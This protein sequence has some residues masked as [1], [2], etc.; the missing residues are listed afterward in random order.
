M[1]MSIG[2]IIEVKHYLYKDALLTFYNSFKSDYMAHCKQAWG[3]AYNSFIKTLFI[4]QENSLRIMFN[5]H[6]KSL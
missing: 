5:T 2:M 1:S 6:K 3:C 4:L